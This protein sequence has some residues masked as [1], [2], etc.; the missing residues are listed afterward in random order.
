MPKI[1]GLKE[2]TGSQTHQLKISPSNVLRYL[3]QLVLHQWRANK[4][5]ALPGGSS[6]FSW[7]HQFS[8]TPSGGKTDYKSNERKRK[9]SLNSGDLHKWGTSK[10]F[11]A[12]SSLVQIIIKTFFEWCLGWGEWVNGMGMQLRTCSE[13]GLNLKRDEVPRCHA[14]LFSQ[15]KQL[16]E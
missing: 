4:H 1:K 5:W 3:M 13:G 15:T 9:Q 2:W 12:H 14:C 16:N 8:N 6:D 10:I 11:L 7:D